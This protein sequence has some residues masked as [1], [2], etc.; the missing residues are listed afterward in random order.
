MG[1]DRDYVSRDLLEMARELRQHQTTAEE[2]LWQ[3]LRNRQL[4]GFKFRRQHP[5]EEGFI[6]DFY[7]HEAKMV[8]E[9]DGSVHWS[10]EQQE[11]DRNRTLGLE[12][13]YDIKVLRFSN[14]EVLHRTRY[15]LFK[16]LDTALDRAS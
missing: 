14:Y 4:G 9:V 3:L 13:Q 6:L 15:V 7:C 12:D 5:I 2:Y 8:I 10:S 16:I 11:H 1:Y